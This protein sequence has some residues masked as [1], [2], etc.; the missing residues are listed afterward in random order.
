MRLVWPSGSGSWWGYDRVGARV[1]ARERFV[2]ANLRLVLMVAKK[3]PLAT[4]VA[5]D[6]VFQEGVVGWH[7]AVDKFDAGKG[8]R[9][10]TYATHCIGFVRRWDG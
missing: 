1:V 4:G 6:D 5:L 2:P 10:S 3:Y 8:F 7:R 9:F